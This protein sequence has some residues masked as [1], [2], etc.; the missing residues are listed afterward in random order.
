MCTVLSSLGGLWY[1]TG[2]AVGASSVLLIRPNAN[3]TDQNEPPSGVCVAMMCN[4]Q[5][6]S[7]LNLAK[8]IEEIFRN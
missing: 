4:L 5:D 6:V 1:H 3:R 8:E 2:T 7:L